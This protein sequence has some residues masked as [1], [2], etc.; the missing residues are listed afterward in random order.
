M[1]SRNKTKS[2]YIVDFAVAAP[3]NDEMVDKQRTWVTPFTV[4]WPQ[5][6][7]S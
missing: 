2:V 1:I 3:L 4:L 6:Q 5:T 7:S